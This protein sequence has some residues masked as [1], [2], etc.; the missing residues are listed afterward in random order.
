[1]QMYGGVELQVHAFLTSS[2]DGSEWSV[3]LPDRSTSEERA[4]AWMLGGPQGASGRSGEEK[5]PMLLPGIKHWSS[6][7]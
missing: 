5:N 1:M 2:L 3:S 6:S 4:M 7:P